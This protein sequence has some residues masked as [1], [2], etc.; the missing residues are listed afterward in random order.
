M[1]IEWCK[2]SERGLPKPDAVFFLTVS[3][4]ALSKRGGFGNERYEVSEIQKKVETN[5]LNLADD[6]WQVGTN[7]D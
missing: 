2:N 3:P 4:E 7:H 6:S 5:Y 1:D